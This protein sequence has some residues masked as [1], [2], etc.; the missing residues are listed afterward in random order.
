MAETFTAK[1]GYAA[2]VTF[3]AKRVNIRGEV[4][5]AIAKGLLEITCVG[6]TIVPFRSYTFGLYDQMSFTVPVVFDEANDAV[7]AIMVD[8]IAGTADT[9]VILDAL[10]GNT[11]LT[12]QALVTY[13]YSAAVDELQM[14]N[15][16]F[17]YTGALTGDLGPAA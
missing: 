4:R 2:T 3:S 9:L 16:T 11:L 8:A 14:L 12:G 5:I 10:G 17:T 6:D 13:E 1:K 7:A 15:V